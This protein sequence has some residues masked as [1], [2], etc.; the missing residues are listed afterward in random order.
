MQGYA[1]DSTNL[2][3]AHTSEIRSGP[4]SHFGYHTL[5]ARPFDRLFA[6]AGYMRRFSV[7]ANV[8]LSI[9]KRS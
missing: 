6:L 4:I 5:A 7:A 2:M 8:H 9:S 1:M 3:A